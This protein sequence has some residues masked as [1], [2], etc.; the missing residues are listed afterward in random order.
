[1]N[2]PMG[3]S[4]GGPPVGPMV[5]MVPGPGVPAGPA[6]F[7][8]PGAPMNLHAPPVFAPPAN[9]ATPMM[10]QPMG[11]PGVGMGGSLLHAW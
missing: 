8:A 5:H 1:M 7:I 4:M 6:G 11:A 10:T 3:M 9:V 2:M